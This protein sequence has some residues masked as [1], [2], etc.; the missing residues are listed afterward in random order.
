MLVS[1]PCDDPGSLCAFR[2]GIVFPLRTGP[3]PE[4][5]PSSRS[6]NH[7]GHRSEPHHV[8]DSSRYLTGTLISP[9]RAQRGNPFCFRHR[10]GTLYLEEAFRQSS[11]THLIP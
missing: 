9:Q 1:P 4:K 7:D 8:E 11:H 10:L 5:M 2:S 3:F 6:G